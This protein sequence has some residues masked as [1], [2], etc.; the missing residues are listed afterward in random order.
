MDYSDHV[1][2]EVYVAAGEFDLG[3]VTGGAL[4]VAH[5]AGLDAG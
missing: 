1:V 2:G 4:V 3:H 5:R